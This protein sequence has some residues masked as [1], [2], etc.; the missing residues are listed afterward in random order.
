M[1]LES[2]V[3]ELTSAVSESTKAAQ[4][5]AQEVAGKMG[6][7]DQELAHQIQQVDQ[8]VS[9]YLADA[10]SECFYV[11]L[12]R[13][14]FAH[15]TDE[16]GALLFPISTYGKTVTAEVVA[17]A[18]TPE[19]VKATVPN[20]LKK[21]IGMAPNAIHLIFKSDEDPSF[22]LP[23]N[24]VAGRFSG[25]FGHVYVV[26]G[27]MSGYGPGE[28]GPRLEHV[29]RDVG[30]WHIDLVYDAARGSEVYCFAPFV[31][32]GYCH[33]ADLVQYIPIQTSMIELNIS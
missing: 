17:W 23:G 18:D 24:P 32:A 21:N 16:H 6:E 22:W 9:D 25:G 26:S 12:F 14:S 3:Q 7:I 5:L 1:S 11:N 27:A 8:Q 13:N 30:S 15:E 28:S 10:R 31:V 4:D 19:I 2:S 29:D 33:D 20:K